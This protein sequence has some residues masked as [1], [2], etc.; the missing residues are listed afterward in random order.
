MALILTKEH[1]S[2]ECITAKQREMEAFKQF[3]VYQEVEDI[4]Q[5]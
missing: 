5:T 2:P 1:R 4:G 3:N